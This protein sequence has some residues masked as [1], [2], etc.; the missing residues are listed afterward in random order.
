MPNRD[1]T[2]TQSTYTDNTTAYLHQWVVVQQ[3]RPNQTDLCVVWGDHRD[4]VRHRPR[5]ARHTH[6][7]CGVNS[8]ARA[9]PSSTSNMEQHRDVRPT[10]SARSEADRARAARRCAPLQGSPSTTSTRPT[11]TR[12]TRADLSPTAMK[13]KNVQDVLLNAYLDLLDITACGVDEH[14]GGDERLLVTSAVVGDTAP[15]G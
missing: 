8:V 13:I 5:S 4:L 15:V 7:S 3:Q 6:V 11:P 14:H 1:A 9:A 10:A 12:A 2:T